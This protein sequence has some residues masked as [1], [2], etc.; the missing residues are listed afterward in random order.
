[1]TKQPLNQK[2]SVFL[3]AKIDLDCIAKRHVRFSPFP[4]FHIRQLTLRMKL[5]CSSCLFFCCECF[6][7]L[8]HDVHESVQ[9]INSFVLPNQ[10][11]QTLPR[12]AREGAHPP[13]HPPPFGDTRPL[14]VQFIF[15]SNPPFSRPGYGLGYRL[16]TPRKR[17]CLA[18]LTFNVHICHVCDGFIDY[19]Q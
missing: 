6:G 11:F 8:V 10:C 19:M 3:K 14:W 4:S 9:T 15:F 1:M 17:H 5:N 2:H 16:V 13:P 18:K 7:L 12:E